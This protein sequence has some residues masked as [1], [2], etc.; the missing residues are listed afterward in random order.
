MLKN[1]LFGVSA[2]DL[3]IFCGV[4][5]LLAG[6]ALADEVLSREHS[7]GPEPVAKTTGP[8]P[9]RHTVLAAGRKRIA[10]AQRE[11]WATLKA[12]Q[13]AA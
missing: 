5:V 2:T 13:K 8:A 4:S 6:T 12:G 3:S 7:D 10:A 9:V 11:R 1:L